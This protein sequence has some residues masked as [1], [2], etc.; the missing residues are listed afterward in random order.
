[1]SVIQGY[2]HF[3]QFA[4]RQGQSTIHITNLDQGL[5][6]DMPAI[7][8]VT[9]ISKVSAFGRAV[10]LADN[11]PYI[12]D[13]DDTGPTGFVMQQHTLRAFYGGFVRDAAPWPSEVSGVRL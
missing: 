5:V 9:L 2:D 3:P 8:L 12:D 7:D 13:A 10:G 11:Y 6:R 1:M 4:M